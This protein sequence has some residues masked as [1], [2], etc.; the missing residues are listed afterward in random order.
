MRQLE[1]ARRQQSRV[2]EL[3]PDELHRHGQPRRGQDF[4]REMIEDLL[5]RHLVFEPLAH[6]AEEVRLLDVF[7]AIENIGHGSVQAPRGAQQALGV[8]RIITA[9]S[10]DCGV[11]SSP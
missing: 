3:R 1:K 6:G 10:A 2:L 9:S 4:L 11:A 7:L 8:D 5:R